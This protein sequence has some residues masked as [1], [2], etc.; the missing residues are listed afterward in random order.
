MESING[1]M[2]ENLLETGSAI[3]CM[4]LESL[5]GMMGENIKESTMMTKNTD[6]L[7]S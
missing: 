5:H 1:L 2:E 6:M 4:D 7:H 3:R